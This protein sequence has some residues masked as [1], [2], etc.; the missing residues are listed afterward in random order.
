V[1]L[2]RRDEAG[3]QVVLRRADGDPRRHLRH[4]LVAD[5]LVDEV[6]GVPEL[7]DLETRRVAEPLK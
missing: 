7:R 1:H 4:G 6:R 3:R 2:E 5:V